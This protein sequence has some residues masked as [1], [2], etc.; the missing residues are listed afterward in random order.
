MEDEGLSLG[1]IPKSAFLH[2]EMN[3]ADSALFLGSLLVPTGAEEGFLG[4]FAILLAALWFHDL[5]VNP[6]F[7]SY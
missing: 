4:S 1:F 7:F 3:T 5:W 6:S 2:K